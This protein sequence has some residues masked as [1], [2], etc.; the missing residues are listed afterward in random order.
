MSPGAMVRIRIKLKKESTFNV[1]Y[2][3]YCSIKK[4]GLIIITN[5]SLEVTKSKIC[6]GG[7][8]FGQYKTEP[9]AVQLF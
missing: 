6:C 9:R 5:L 1:L 8:E 3:L 2:K 7:I 4:W